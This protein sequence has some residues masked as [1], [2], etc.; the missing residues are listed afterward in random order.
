MDSIL[1]SYSISSWFVAV[2]YTR[3]KL[4][5][6][7]CC[8][9]GFGIKSFIGT[10][11]ASNK[12][13]RF[14]PHSGASNSSLAKT[15]STQHSSSQSGGVISYLHHRIKAVTT[16]QKVHSTL[17]MKGSCGSAMLLK[18]DLFVLEAGAT[19]I[20]VSHS[21]SYLSVNSRVLWRRLHCLPVKCACFPCS[22]SE[23]HNSSSYQAMCN[24]TYK[25]NLKSSK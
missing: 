18:K 22:Q 6:F 8:L 24:V 14:K 11:C 1:G 4:W 7:Q 17:L 3:G 23:H 15:V 5:E 21:F 9:F 20:L 13:Y 19:A 10:N 16:E 25:T 2:C 12:G